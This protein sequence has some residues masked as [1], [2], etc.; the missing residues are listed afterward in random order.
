VSSYEISSKEKVDFINFLDFEPKDLGRIIS[1]LL[2]NTNLESI[3]FYQNDL[4]SAAWERLFDTFQGIETLRELIFIENNLSEAKGLAK[5]ITRNT[6]LTSFALQEPNI[7]DEGMADLVLAIA[8]NKALKEFR[9]TKMHLSLDNLRMLH[10]VIQD[11]PSLKTIIL[12]DCG[13]DDEGAMIIANALVQNPSLI[14]VALP[15]NNIWHN[16]LEH[17]KEIT[18]THKLYPKAKIKQEKLYLTDWEASELPTK[19]SP[20]S[21]IIKTNGHT[22]LFFNCE[23]AQLTNECVSTPIHDKNKD[24]IFIPEEYKSLSRKALLS[25]DAAIYDEGYTI[26]FD[27]FAK[28]MLTLPIMQ[29][30]K[31]AD[32]SGIFKSPILGS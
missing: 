22:D 4:S 20:P 6:A 8:N 25:I 15:R 29:G 7:S 2:A 11:K 13:I 18:D 30:I 12:D 5:E 16:I 28:A 31:V 3:Y 19:Y 1:S 9:L 23:G 21:T 26:P 27:N 10:D 14:Q 17:I 24:S 32:T